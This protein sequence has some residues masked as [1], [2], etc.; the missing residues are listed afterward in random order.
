MKN[1]TG[2]LDNLKYATLALANRNQYSHAE[3]FP[4]IVLDNFLDEDLVKSLSKVFPEEG[5]GEGWV[6]CGK[7]ETRKSYIQDES[8]MPLVMRLMFREFN[9]PK[10]VLFMEALTG[11]EGLIPDPYLIGGGAHLSRPGD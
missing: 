1:P 7:E 3:P 11:I 8:C 10:L 6:P 9:S 5:K 2:I 4:H